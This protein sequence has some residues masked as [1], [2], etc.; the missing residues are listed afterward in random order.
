MKLSDIT[1]LIKECVDEINDNWSYYHFNPE[2]GYLEDKNDSP[3]EAFGKFTSVEEA[4]EYLMYH[5][6]PGSVLAIKEMTG[7]GAVAGYTGPNA[8]SGGEKDINRK[9]KIAARSMP[10]GKVLSRS[11]TLDEM[12]LDETA[13][14][15]R[16]PRPLE[17]KE[18]LI[19]VL[20]TLKRAGIPCKCDSQ[21]YVLV[22]SYHAKKAKQVLESLHIFNQTSDN[23]ESDV[24]T[25]DLEALTES[26]YH[27]FKKSDEM[28]NNAKVSYSIKEI[29][30]LLREV[31]YLANISNRLKTETNVSSSSFWKRT[32]GDIEKI[33]E[34]IKNI[35]NT[36]KN[37]AK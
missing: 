36:I 31:E 20:E 15:I 18:E 35:S 3:V 28:R 17:E 27:N 11:S 16:F 8:F 4:D 33:N 9:K 7:T 13:H 5:K 21:H 1:K 30:K 24:E 10:G 23:A 14:R 26:R 22:N 19:F 25:D 6:I 32:V 29:H 37:I 34:K 12:E 2:T